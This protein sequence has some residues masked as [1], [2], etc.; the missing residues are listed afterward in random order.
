MNLK[1]LF[2]IWS[3]FIFI[4]WGSDC[5][6]DCIISNNSCYYESHINILQDFIDNNISLDNIE[7]LELGYQ[8]WNNNKLINLYLGNLQI[9][10]V[11]DSIGIL[12]DLKSLD[13]SNNNIESMPDAICEIYPYYTTLNLSCP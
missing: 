13:L 6:K 1:N 8:E 7:P 10:V 11:P 9:N 12:K 5:P 2:I 4:I 3:L